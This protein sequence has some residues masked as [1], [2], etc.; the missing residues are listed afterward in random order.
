MD[1]GT[2]EPLCVERHS[3]NGESA[4][5]Q[6]RRFSFRRMCG[7]DVH[8]LTNR[9]VYRTFMSERELPFNAFLS[10]RLS[11]AVLSVLLHSLHRQRLQRL[12]SSVHSVDYQLTSV[13]LGSSC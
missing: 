5:H 10:L 7:A 1:N 8:I 6:S 4:S 9:C 12:S 13:S 3:C 2:F 11:R